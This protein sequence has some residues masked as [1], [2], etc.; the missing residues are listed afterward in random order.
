M[1]KSV[2]KWFVYIGP[3]RIHRSGGFSLIFLI[4][5]IKYRVEVYTASEPGADTEA[6]LFIQLFGSHGDSGERVLFNCLNNKT[7]FQGGQMDMFEIEAV[8]LQ[9]IE[10]V[11]MRH[12]EKG[13]G[14]LFE[15]CINKVDRHLTVVEPTISFLCFVVFYF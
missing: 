11:V 14:N 3:N 15:T 2:R 12:E 10:K 13:K 9:E 5:V 1:H 4:A 7:P 6:E 8:E